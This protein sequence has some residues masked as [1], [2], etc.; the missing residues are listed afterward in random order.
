[1]PAV[2]RAQA[3]LPLLVE[4]PVGC[5]VREDELTWPQVLVDPQRV[6]AVLRSDLE[7]VLAGPVAAC[8]D[9]LQSFNGQRE[10]E[11]ALV[12]CRQAFVAHR[13]RVLAVGRV[14]VELLAIVV[15]RDV[16]CKLQLRG[17]PVDGAPTDPPDERARGSGQPHS[18]HGSSGGTPSVTSAP[19]PGPDG[20]VS[21]PSAIWGA[22]VVSSSRHGTSS[23][24]TSR[25][26]T[27]GIAA[28]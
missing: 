11:V 14:Q 10:V 9:V 20:I 23:T 26:R 22:A 21:L 24:S 28:H 27:F 7:D 16:A 3:A 19:Q 25:M 15:Q 8:E 17:A 4:V 12:H 5:E 2:R 13:P 18:G 6:R 1:D